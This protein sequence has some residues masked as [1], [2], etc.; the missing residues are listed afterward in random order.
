MFHFP[1]Y[2]LIILKY[3][4]ILETELG[5]FIGFIQQYVLLCSLRIVKVLFALE[6]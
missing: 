2:V 1:C 6:M 5:Q 3:P 4:G